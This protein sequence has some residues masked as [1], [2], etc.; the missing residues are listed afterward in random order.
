MTA[1]EQLK[2][3]HRAIRLALILLDVL[4]SKIEKEGVVEVEKLEKLSEFFSMFADRCHHGKEENMLFPE[5]EK[6]G[7]PR[8]GGPIGVMLMEHETGRDFLRILREG[9]KSYKINPDNATAKKIAESIKGYIDLLE[10]HIYK[11]NNVLFVMAEVHLPEKVQKELFDKFEEFELNEIGA[12]KHEEF[13]KMLD[14]LKKD[15]FSDAEILDVRDIPPV[16][17]HALILEEFDELN[18]SESL[19]LINDHDPK[20]LYYQFNEEKAGKFGWEYISAGP[21]I[22]S[23]KITK[24]G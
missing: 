4:R 11:E 1:V 7:I 2:K 13:H 24:T 15:L 21:T 3:E 14:E 6:A 19:I 17:R 22:W 5:L 12:G 18:P 8:E 10:Q 9:V 16:Q 20:P 23:V